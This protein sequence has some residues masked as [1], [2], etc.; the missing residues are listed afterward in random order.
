MRGGGVGGRGTKKIFAEGK[1][2][3]KKKNSSTPINPTKYS[4]Y[5]LKRIHSRNLITEKNFCGTKIPPPPPI[6]FLMVRPLHHVKTATVFL[7][8]LMLLLLLLCFVCCCC[9]C[10]RYHSNYRMSKINITCF[11]ANQRRPACEIRNTYSS[12][13]LLNSCGMGGLFGLCQKSAKRRNIFVSKN[14]WR[15]YFSSY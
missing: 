3:W 14:A 10:F 5:G 11:A 6:N 15:T 9:C 7:F 4:W 2:K 12:F 8:V 1:I 13:W